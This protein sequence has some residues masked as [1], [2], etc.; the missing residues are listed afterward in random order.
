[1]DGG[2]R[3]TTSTSETSTRVRGSSTGVCDRVFGE[4]TKDGPSVRE[5]VHM[6]SSITHPWDWY[7]DGDRPDWYLPWPEPKMTWRR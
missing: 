2:T 3:M 4:Y 5:D 1:M 7:F 6:E